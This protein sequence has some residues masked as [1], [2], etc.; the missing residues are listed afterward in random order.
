MSCCLAALAINR[1][2]FGVSRSSATWGRI[3]V[4]VQLAA[5]LSLVLF[6]RDHLAQASLWML[7]SL[8]QAMQG[9]PIEG[10]SDICRAARN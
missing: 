3:L 4:V 8:E 7:S 1:R 9:T 10:A 6:H 2:L 5:A